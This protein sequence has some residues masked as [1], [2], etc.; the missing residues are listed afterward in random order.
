MPVDN[1]IIVGPVLFETCMTRIPAAAAL[2]L[3]VTAAVLWSQTTPIV[4]GRVIRDITGEP[5]PSVRVTIPSDALSAPVILTD[6]QGRFS[7]RAPS[8]PFR[9]IASKTG[10]HRVE[11]ALTTAA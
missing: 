11:L 7:L 5:L 8:G 6:S 10:Y 3:L 1:Q 2:G 4:T 9:L